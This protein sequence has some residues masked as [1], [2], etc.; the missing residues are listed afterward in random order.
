MARRK[1]PLSDR[2]RER[3]ELDRIWSRIVLERDGRTCQL[4]GRTGNNP[5][6]VFSRKHLSTRH[7]PDNGI[8]LCWACH[9]HRA[10]SDYET[11]RDF[12]I[13]RWGQDKYDRMKRRAYGVK[14]VD[15]A[16]TFIALTQS[17]TIFDRKEA[18]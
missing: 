15:H 4:C 3:K 8:T 10:H 9:I 17:Q 11:F 12:I 6:H 7:D 1:L 13:G 16:L 18:R 14:G 2:K 5:H